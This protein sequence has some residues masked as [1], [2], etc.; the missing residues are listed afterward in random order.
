VRPLIAGIEDDE[1]AGE[2]VNQLMA[3]MRRLNQIAAD[4]EV[5][6]SENLAADVNGFVAAYTAAFGRVRS[7]DS[8]ETLS[9]SAQIKTMLP[10]EAIQHLIALAEPRD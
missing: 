4:R 7:L 8:G 6:S 3:V 9:A 5:K 10:L 1:A 2:K